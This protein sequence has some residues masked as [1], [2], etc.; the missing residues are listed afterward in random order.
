RLVLE[1]VPLLALAAL[2]GVAT[3]IAQ[4]TG[5]AMVSLDV[6]PLWPRVANAV[7]GN[8]RYLAATIWPADLAY[9]YPY[10]TWTAATVLG[11][12]M[13]LVIAT[14]AAFVLRHRRPYLAAGWA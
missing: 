6:V 10:R 8:V 7:V 2:T 5:G 13:V 9:F 1:K 12:A 14:A 4:R 11:A 3:F